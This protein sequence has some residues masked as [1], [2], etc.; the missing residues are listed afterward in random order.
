[1]KIT[2]PKRIISDFKP[3]VKE[4]VKKEDF[5]Y[6]I[7][8]FVIL[9]LFSI[10][11]LLISLKSQ[12]YIKVGEPAPKDIIAPTS[13]TYIDQEKTEQEK[14]LARQSVSPLYTLDP[15]VKVKVINNVEDTFNRILNIVN[16]NISNDEK[17]NELVEILGPNSNT[18]AKMI[19][20]MSSD[21][22]LKTKNY[23][24]NSLNNIYS[25]GIRDSDISSVIKNIENELKNLKFSD[26]EKSLTLFLA[27]SFIKPNLVIDQEA[28]NRAIEEAVKKVKPVKVFVPEG[29]VIIEKGKVI[30]EE[31]I[32]FLQKLGLYKTLSFSTIFLTLI[33]SLIEAFL[34]LIILKEKKNKRKKFLEF[35]T[36]LLPLSIGSIILSN[37]SPYFLLIPLTTLLFIEF[38]DF[39]ETIIA[40][41]L[42]VLL[43]INNINILNFILL[44]YLAISIVLAFFVEPEKKIS[45]FLTYNFIASIFA[46]FS[47]FFINLSFK[48]DLSIT[49]LNAFYAFLN[50]IFTAPVALAIS[51][52]IEH[53]FNEAK[54]LRLIELG[55][56]NT[57]LLKELANLAPGTFSH[58][59]M[60]A[61]IASQAAEEIK[62]NSLLTRVGALY[63]DIGK[64][65]YPYYFTE[66]QADVPNIHNSISPNL[67]RVIIINHV[68]DGV[69]LAKRNRLPEDI[70]HFIETHHGKSIITY[71]YR[72]AKEVDPN[73]NE[74]DFRYPGPLP[75]TKETAIVALADAVE[76]AS[77]SLDKDEIDLRKIEE[78]VNRLVQEKIDDGELS[79]SNITLLEIE[80]I[81]KSFVKSL[82]SLYHKR[83]KYP[84]NE[85]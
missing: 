57:P 34:V 59:L 55:D 70:I 28:T 69:E 9:F 73:V 54:F 32:K 47:V 10:S 77:R 67:S 79:N 13:I 29:T 49:S 44:S 3:F 68:K 30:T 22:L 16:Q 78:L 8:S 63:H 53:I 85:N 41:I 65:V 33:F 18:Y 4:F 27:K 80:K 62:A 17:I 56:L 1:M 71:F 52:I 48:L 38:F 58:S 64:I 66:N 61:T 6:F 25:A 83:E 24:I 37:Y 26:S 11:L 72:K 2:K 40:L 50:F 31:D 35:L 82:L 42:F 84:E 20:S 39:K 81:K 19:L 14:E 46:F 15:N 7:V 36:I 5:K 75:D 74:D 45:N 12:I 76:A 51:Y 23:L 60:V 21:S 43:T